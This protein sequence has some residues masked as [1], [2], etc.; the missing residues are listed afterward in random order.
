MSFADDLDFLAECDIHPV[1]LLPKC[2]KRLTA[3]SGTELQ[4][5]KLVICTGDGNLSIEECLE[6]SDE[7]VPFDVQVGKTATF[8]E[9]GSS[10]GRPR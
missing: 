7:G 5:E 9:S 10:K 3:L 6:L 2:A 4:I 1:T 8:T